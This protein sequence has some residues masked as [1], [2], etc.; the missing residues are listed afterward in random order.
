MSVR[1]FLVVLLLLSSILAVAQNLPPVGNDDFYNVG[2]QI[3]LAI[4]DLQG[5]LANDTDANF[6]TN[7]RSR[8]APVIG[9]SSG[10]L[11]LDT[12]G[13]FLYTPNTGFVG[14][15]SF[16]YRVCDE[17]TPTEVVS[18]FDFDDPNLAL[19]TIGPNATSVNPSAGQT[20]CGIYFPSGAGGSAGFDINI[21]NTGGIFDF[22]SFTVSFEYEDQESTADIITA[23]NFRVY[24][25]SGNNMGLRVDVINGSTGLPDSF[26]VNLG[27]FVSG[28][29]PYTIHYDELSGNVTYTAN[30]AT[31][32]FAL[33]PAFSPLNT[34]LATNII[35]GRFMDGSGSSRPSLCSME[36]VD[37]SYLCDTATVY[38]NV[39]ANIVTNRRITYRVK[40][41]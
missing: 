12:D 14:T 3:P 26:T 21:P 16:T 37:N 35:L 39:V 36:F 19:A 24:H 41:N 38:L 20:G 40:R 31:S 13:S 6:G 17:G 32:V 7:L 25:I 33:A 2:Y 5:V 18:R 23:G 34:G 4:D 29:V 11:T 10:S 22:T 9:P 28:N 8:T 1:S 15:D 27:S 30:G